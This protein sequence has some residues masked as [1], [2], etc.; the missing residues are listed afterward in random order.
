MDA[1]HQG[2][3]VVTLLQDSTYDDTDPFEARPRLAL[4]RYIGSLMGIQGETY[5][6]MVIG[7]ERSEDTGGID[8]FSPWLLGVIMPQQ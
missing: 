3:S 6:D 7:K 4:F 8:S 2:I 5:L 1:H